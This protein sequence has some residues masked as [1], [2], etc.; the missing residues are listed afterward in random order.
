[1]GNPKL[2]SP[3]DINQPEYRRFEWPAGNGIGT[4]RSIA[5]AYGVFASGGHELA[6]DPE[7]LR[8]LEASPTPPIRGIRGVILKVDTSLS[9]GF[10]KPSRSFRF[11]SS[12]RAYGTIGAGGSFGFADPD[13]GVGFAYAPNRHGFHLWD[14]PRE[15]RLRD[16]VFACL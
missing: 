5:K 16:T 9:M 3:A 8:E 2:H 14:D 15:K 11:G 12:E 1:M 13:S 4:V 10:M 7:T 6:I